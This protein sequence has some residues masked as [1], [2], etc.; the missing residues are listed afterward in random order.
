M[1]GVSR[2]STSFATC[3]G[4]ARPVLPALDSWHLLREKMS[5]HNT[6]QQVKHFVWSCCDLHSKAPHSVKRCK[7]PKMASDPPRLALS[8]LRFA[9][10]VIATMGPA[11]RQPD[12]FNRMLDAGI[13]AVRF[14]MSLGQLDDHLTALD[15]VSKTAKE[16]K[17]LCAVCLDVSGHVCQ[18][19]QPHTWKE[20]GWPHYHM[21]VKIAKG[22]SV[23]LT[24]REGA[25]L[26]VPEVRFQCTP[27][28]LLFVW[29]LL[30]LLPA[31]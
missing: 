14:D 10:A 23:V 4:A 28:K 8:N 26:S 25:Y 17:N 27:Y 24:T 6:V 2:T 11:I 9:F 7:H 1:P 21:S 5:K 13:T 12:M 15:T 30:S 19:L 20:D 16:N 29:V 18:V 31:L 22:Q 3:L